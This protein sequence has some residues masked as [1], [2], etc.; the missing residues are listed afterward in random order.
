MSHTEGEKETT[1]D[2]SDSAISECIIFV[3]S[4]T[5]RT[6]QEKQG[7][8][9]RTQA[10]EKRIA[11]QQKKIF[12]LCLLTHLGVATRLARRSFAIHLAHV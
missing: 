12:K 2:V 11:R 1:R 4:V 7:K 5:D 8:D 6:E 9:W 10:S 3:K